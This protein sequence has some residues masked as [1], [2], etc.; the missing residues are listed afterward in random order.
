MFRLPRTEESIGFAFSGGGARSAVQAGAVRALTEASI[1]PT[2]VAG[3]SAGAVN[4]AWLALY[5]DRLE[6]LYEIWLRLRTKDVFPGGRVRILA[7]MARRGYVHD[8]SMWE[9]ALVHD[10]GHASFEETKIPLV[11]TAVRLSDGQR[12]L[13]D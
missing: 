4:A 3:T 2:V 12:V 6:K 13:F 11:V 8:A 5:P 1:W 10:I 7:N 9:R